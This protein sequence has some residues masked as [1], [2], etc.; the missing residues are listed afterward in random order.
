MAQMIE[1]VGLREF[2]RSLRQLDKNLPKG[3]RLAGNAAANIVVDEAKPRVP[4]RSGKAAGSV[5]AASTRTAARV[6]GGGPKVPYYPWLD[7][8]GR[9]GRRHQTKR[10]FIKEG[11]YIWAAFADR[12][13]EVQQTLHQELAALARSAGLGGI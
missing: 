6:S 4:R 3:L 11:R 5:K 10:P 8:G 1:I 12:K 7:F 9:V 13:P 2:N